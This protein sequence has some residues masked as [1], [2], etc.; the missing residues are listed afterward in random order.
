M[1]TTARAPHPLSARVRAELER[2]IED[3]TLS[4]GERLNEV[5]LARQLGVSRGP[6]REAA[7]LLER[8]GLV[9]VIL[10]RGAFIRTVPLDEA[11][12]TYA[13]NALLFGFGCAQLAASITAGQ[14]L[15]L[16]GLYE[17]MEAAVTANDRE[18]FFAHNV[19][20]HERIMEFTRNRQ[21]EA[22]YLQQTRKLML[23]RRR[24]F[25]RASS[26]AESNAGHRRILDALLAGNAEQARLAAEEH[27]S[28]GRARFLSAIE[29]PAH[30]AAPCAPG[31]K[32]AK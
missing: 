1:S 31:P 23:F 14:A 12:D 2:M 17:A 27:T 6:V 29:A 18:A 20:F 8:V 3:G 9:T 24:S 19:S 32:L 16:R 10:N 22:V 5:A 13:L 15:A 26:M 30:A 11:L 28:S 7:R 25:D 21:V 4:P